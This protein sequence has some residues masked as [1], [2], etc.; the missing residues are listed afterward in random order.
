MNFTYKQIWLINFPVMMSLLME[1]LINLTDTI[2]LGHVGEVELGASALAGMYY[3]AIYMLGFGFSLGLQVMIARRNGE[4]NLQKTGETFWQGM[5]F[6]IT[7]SILTFT[8]S[9]LFS[10]TLLRT[11]ISSDQIYLAVI[12]YISWR[13]YSFLSV[14][15]ILAYR[16]FYVGTTKTRV[17]TINSILLVTTNTLLNYLL[18]FGVG[19]FPRL[20]IAGAAIASSVAEAVALIYLV[21]YTY[22]KVDKK[23]YGWRCSFNFP[24]L[25]QLFQLSSWTM[26]RSFFCIAPW[27][28]FFIAIEHLGERQLAAGNVVRS[29]S[30]ILFVIVNSFATT[31][32]SLVSNL[33]GAGQTESVMPV[34]WKT[35]KL[36]YAVGTPFI[37]VAIL[38]SN[39]ILGIYTNSKE[40]VETAIPPFL[41]MLSTYFLATPAY[42][43]CNAIIGTG[44]TKTAFVFQMITITIY[45]GYLYGLASCELPLVIYWTAEQL[46]VLLLLGLA[47]NYLKKGSWKR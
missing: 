22:F 40:V 24:L 27:F 19:G 43:Y 26:I 41:L 4:G 8:F 47:L 16:A 39:Q 29:V 42:T 2:F 35:V 45:L 7:L 38:M 46:Y 23:K 1:Q 34:C 32:I 14:F 33:I 28:L 12:Q 30:V 37:L 36:S 31:G 6:L 44:K 21:T 9:K 20:G 13:D 3:I 15:P 5:F 25:R 17:L 10:P 18:I 11:V